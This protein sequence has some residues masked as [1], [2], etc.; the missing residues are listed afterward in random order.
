M[1]LQGSAHARGL[2]SQH[3]ELIRASGISDAVRD[4]RGYWTATSATDLIALGFSTTQ[5]IV[6]ALVIPIHGTGGNVVSHQA[7]PDQ[8]RIGKNGKP[9]KYETPFG[10]RMHLDV[11]PGVRGDI[12]KPA[13]PLVVTEGL[14]KADAAATSGMCCIALLGVWNW[15]GKNQAGGKV[16]LAEWESVA[17]NDR[18]V[19]IVFDSDV[20]VKREVRQALERLDGFLASRG[21][22]VTALQLPT[23]ANGD[24]VGLDDFLAAGHTVTELLALP[25]LISDSA[26]PAAAPV[27]TAALLEEVR[28]IWGRYLVLPGGHFYDVVALWVL[29]AHAITA[30]ET[31]P[32]SSS[33]VRRRS[34]AR[35][36]RW[37][38]LNSSSR[39]R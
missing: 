39:R 6:P 33:R 24:K 15:R 10:S 23:G 18:D 3:A 11:P 25:R 30:F 7:R 26:K 9:V 36:G 22:R 4:A 17:L 27:A 28:T 16:A 20:V 13:K 19:Y 37:R 32:E 38:W 8:P 35:P 21:A 29:H 31:T 14:R 1:Q 12:A 2:H 5:A 34:R